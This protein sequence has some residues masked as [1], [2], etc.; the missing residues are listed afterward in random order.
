MAHSV[1]EQAARAVK[2]SQKVVVEKRTPSEILKGIRVNRAAKLFV[3]PIDVDFLLAAFDAATER[4]EVAEAQYAAAVK[5]ITARNHE[6]SELQ[7]RL[8]QS[9]KLIQL[10]VEAA[11]LKQEEIKSAQGV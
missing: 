2:N 7:D 11:I 5:I 1:S 10:G 9:A 4:A 6:V 8:E 3:T